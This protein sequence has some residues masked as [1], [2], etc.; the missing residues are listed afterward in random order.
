VILLQANDRLVGDGFNRFAPDIAP[1]CCALPD[2]DFGLA[3]DAVI[4][5]L[6]G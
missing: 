4:G 1:L 3:L 6:F 2:E 5:R